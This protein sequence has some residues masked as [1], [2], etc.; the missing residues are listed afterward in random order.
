MPSISQGQYF[1][2]QIVYSS[3]VK[4]T[5]LKVKEPKQG[6]REEEIVNRVVLLTEGSILAKL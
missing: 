4:N 6:R 3:G 2:V 1:I 5:T